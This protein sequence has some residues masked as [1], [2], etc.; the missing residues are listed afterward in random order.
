MIGNLSIPL[1]TL[2]ACDSRSTCLVSACITYIYETRV[3]LLQFFGPMKNNMYPVYYFIILC[4]K[5]LCGISDWLEAAHI[6]SSLIGYHMR[7]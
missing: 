3:E 2:Q 6:K 5:I 4:R 1:Q 7:A